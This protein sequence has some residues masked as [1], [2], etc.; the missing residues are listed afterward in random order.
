MINELRILLTRWKNSNYISVSKYKSLYCSDGIL[1]KVYG[2]PKI[3]K[4]GNPFRIIISS[5]DSPF[6]SM[7]SFLQKLLT[8]HIPNTFS[9]VENSFQLT[10]KL[11]NIHIDDNH[12]LISL[13]VISLFTNIP[14]DLALESVSKRWD[15]ISSICNIP[16]NEFINALKMI[17]NSTYFRFNNQIYKQNFGAPI[18]SSLSSIIADLV[19]R[20]LEE[21]PLRH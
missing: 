12:M 19:L 6:H 21:R 7:S 8:E 9:H 17:L 1:P 5:I 16:Y 3:H 2:L 10:D 14:L 18:G 11:R 4:P 13:D 20:D 15:S